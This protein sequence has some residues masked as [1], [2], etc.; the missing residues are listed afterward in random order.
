MSIFRHRWIFGLLALALVAS[1]GSGIYYWRMR[2]EP[3]HYTTAQVTRGKV[4]RSVTMTGALNPLVTVQVGSY[5]SGIVRWLGCDFNTEVKVGQVC[6]RIDPLPFQVVVDQDKA[7]VMTAE[8]QRNKDQAALVYAK[9]SY[10]RDQKLLEQDIVSKD[11]VDND[12]SAY[13]QARAQLALDEA[14]IVSKKASL[15]AAEVNLGYTEIVSPVNG[16]VITR[17]V[18]VGQTV[19]TSLQSSTLFLIGKDLTKMQVDTNVS[20]ADVAAVRPGQR[21]SFT[22][23]AYPDKTFWGVVSQIRQA[24]ETVQ[25]VVTYDVVITA[26]NPDRLLFPGMTADTH[27][28]IDER[29]DV[30]RV[31]LPAVRFSPEGFARRRPQGEHAAEHDGEARREHRP[32]SRI[33]VMKEGHLKPVRVTTGL[34]DGTLIEVSGDGLTADDEVVVTEARSVEQQRQPTDVKAFRRGGPRF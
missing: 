20:E 34:D 29:Q 28:I 7:D 26:D 33:W 27:I 6:A 2:A 14:N 16:T 30:L 15:K 17:N 19:V 10:E 23:Q 1:A 13:N 21:A 18:D 12:L 4:E 8:A 32:G 22:V 25:S 31:P 11:Q 24:P 3:P 9:I 5:V